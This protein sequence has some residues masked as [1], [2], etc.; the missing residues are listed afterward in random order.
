MKSRS[1]TGKTIP[2]GFRERIDTEAVI[3]ACCQHREAQRV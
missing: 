1:V 3:E 2:S